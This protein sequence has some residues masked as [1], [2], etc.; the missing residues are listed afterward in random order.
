MEENLRTAREIQLTMLPQQYPRFPPTPFRRSKAP[1]S[2]STA[3]SRPNRSAAIFSASPPF[4]TRGGGVHLR[5]DRPRR[6]RRAGHR[7]DPRAGRGIEAA[8]ARS[9]HFLRKLNSD[10]CSILKSTGSPMLTTAFYAVADCRTGSHAVRQCRPS[11]AAAHPPLAGR[12]EPLANATGR[13]QPALG[14]FDDPPYQPAESTP[15]SRRF[16]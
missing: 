16:S 10:L 3:T 6:P 2:S 15:Q 9:R 8:G 4:P 12:V 14:L 1:F 5:R 13:S 7:D 11:Q